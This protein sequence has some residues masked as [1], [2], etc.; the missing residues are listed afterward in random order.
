VFERFD[1]RAYQV[2]VLAGI[3]ARDRRFSHVGTESLLVGLLLE[4]KARTGT[5]SGASSVLLE[6]VREVVGQ[7]VGALE[8]SDPEAR[9]IDLTPRAREVLRHAEDEAAEARAEHVTP[10]HI[11]LAASRVGEG[12]G[13]RAL[14]AL[15]ISPGDLRARL[16]G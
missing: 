16:Y 14:E 6:R 4:T 11:L 10:A 1:E 7:R 13:L 3:E 2:V 9:V 12:E 15:R 8:K 5:M